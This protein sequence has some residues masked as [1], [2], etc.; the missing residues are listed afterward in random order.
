[1]TV[2]HPFEVAQLTAYYP[3]H[4]GGV[5]SV[6]KHLAEG[7]ADRHHV[8]VLTSDIDSGIFPRLQ[9]QGNLTVERYPSRHVANV[10]LFPG[11]ALGV[12][13]LPRGTILHAHVTQAFV[14]EVAALGAVSGTRPL[15]AHYHM[16]LKVTGRRG[17][18][19][20][21]KRFVLGPILRRAARVLVLSPQQADEV[22]ERYS[23]ASTRVSVFPNGVEDIYFQPGV[24]ERRPKG[25]FRVLFVGRL[26][27][28]KDLPLLFAAVRRLGT[29][30][31]VV[32]VGD[33][34]LR[35]QIERL[36]Q[37]EG[38]GRIRIIGK[39][40]SAQVAEWYRWADVFLSSSEREG[41]P[42]SLLE[43]MASG[44]PIVA[45]DVPGTRE[46]V[47]AA[48]LLVDRSPEA[49]ATAI[50]DLRSHPRMAQEMVDRGRRSVEGRRWSE[51]IKQLECI[52][53]EI[54]RRLK[55]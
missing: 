21:W 19:E 50:E 47:A 8:K 34:E 54:S 10:P 22:I 40:N 45:T 39:Q 27:P 9:N 1:V 24:I 36:A 53:G 3:P 55:T 17:M 51:I 7:L 25:P 48:G 31:E 20:H 44:V 46:T 52:Y 23:I 6:A 12:M 49:L 15:V 32:I 42:L 16:D 35:P 38:A 5:E 26:S 4:L 41:M 33:G 2:A 14:P 13:Q 29:E 30:A 11:A 43:A 18:F 37:A 28:Q